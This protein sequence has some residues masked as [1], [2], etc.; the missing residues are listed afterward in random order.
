MTFVPHWIEGEERPGPWVITVD[1]AMNGVPPW[2]GG[3]DL[4]LPQA[5]MG[6][7]IAYDIGAKGLAQGLGRLL[8]SPVVGSTFSRLV[9]DANRG[10]KDPTQVMRLYDGTIIPANRAATPGD[11]ARR[12]AELWE[13]YHAEVTRLLAARPDAAILA[14]HSFTPQLR[15]RPPRPWQ[16]GILSTDDRRVA[17]PLLA[18]LQGEADL[19]V[20]D[21]EPYKGHLPGDSVDRHALSQNRLNALLEVRQDLIGDPAGQAAWAQRLAPHF[22]TAL[23]AARQKGE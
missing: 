21:N 3:G 17:D 11:I 1:H 6:R 18:S 13:G 8:D 12:Q 14:V 22:A 2:V 16:V 9:I 20:G 19:T 7:H 23:S 5:D 10:P 4:G 15:A